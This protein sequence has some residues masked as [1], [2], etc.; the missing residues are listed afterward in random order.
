MFDAYVEYINM[1]TQR[2]F[3]YTYCNVLSHIRVIATLQFYSVSK[4]CDGNSLSS[5]DFQF[6]YIGCMKNELSTSHI[7]LW[8]VH[9][10]KTIIIMGITFK[11]I[12]KMLAF[13]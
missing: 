7:Q 1:C 12:N 4:V 6:Y 13:T 10:I 3:V 5:T 11:K 2:Q 9:E 8:E